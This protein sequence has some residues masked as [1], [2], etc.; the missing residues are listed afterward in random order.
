MLWLCWALCEYVEATGDTELCAVELN[1]V[2]SPL[3]TA[4]EWDRYETPEISAAKAS[5]LD[6][7]RAALECCLSRGLGKNS[8]PLFGSGDWNDAFD[9]TGG[10]SVWLAWFL[11]HCAERFARLLKRLGKNDHER[12]EGFART[13]A[14]SA[15]KAWNGQFFL[16]GFDAEGQ[17][18]GGNARIDSVAQS[19][20]AFCEQ[21]D[22]VKAQSAVDNALR[23]LF[24]RENAL[25]R[26]FD[27]P[28]RASEPYIGYI[29]SYG[30]GFRE[31]GGHYTHGAL[32]LAMACLRQG[33]ANE[34][35]ELIQAL[36]P[37]NR[38]ISRYEAEPFVL[39]ADVYS[40]PG[41]EGEAG[42][43]WYTGSAGW[44][45]RIAAQ[46]LLG[47]KLRDGRLYIEPALPAALPEISIE[48]R[49]AEGKTHSIDMRGGSI[50]VDGKKY[51]GGPI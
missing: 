31:N 39:S 16:R 3:L 36:L 8:L 12:Y 47:L 25:V 10:E 42:W 21:A 9:R 19:W 46:E 24:D 2:S 51:S 4:A 44:F 6:H 27:P 26:L 34:A 48:L 17:A 29:S 40:A 28:Y 43:S 20:S 45:F 23:Q 5:V 32:W 13:V 14:E 41:H 35:F 1:Y 22:P 7:A 15:D 38:D 18:L 50:L 11:S 49:T 37:E 33:R 30:E